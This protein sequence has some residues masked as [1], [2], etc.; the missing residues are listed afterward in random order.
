[1]R[2][3]RRFLHVKSRTWRGILLDGNIATNFRQLLWLSLGCVDLL[4]S[5]R[6][7]LLRMPGLEALQLQCESLDLLLL[8]GHGIFQSLDI[9]SSNWWW[10]G[11]R[12]SLFGRCTGCWV[13]CPDARGKNCERQS[14][15]K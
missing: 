13:F 10:R 15:E 2:L 8:R 6:R 12:G 4:Y 9:G 11:G 3:R 1:M 14:D 7:G 5:F